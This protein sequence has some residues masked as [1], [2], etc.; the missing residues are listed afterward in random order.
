MP[1]GSRPGRGSEAPCPPPPPLGA[2]PGSRLNPSRRRVG[3]P[4]TVF[5]GSRRRQN[6]RPCGRARV[7]RT[8][9][10]F[11]KERSGRLNLIAAPTRPIEDV[12]PVTLQDLYGLPP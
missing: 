2:A 7:W 5:I 8:G 6:R 3:P 4:T 9:G 11:W 10:D 1:A 12:V